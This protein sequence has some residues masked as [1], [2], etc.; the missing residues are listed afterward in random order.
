MKIKKNSPPLGRP[1]AFDSEKALESALQV[2]WERGYEGASLADL[3][4]AMGINRPSLYG[5]YGNKEALFLKV[6]D[7]YARGP[8]AFVQEAL[9]EPT[10]R[11]VAERMVRCAAESLGEID[12]PRGCLIVQSTLAC[13]KEANPIRKE[14][15]ARRA[16]GLAALRQR[17]ER[18]RSEGDLPV[19]S[20]STDL[21]RYIFSVIYGMAIQSVN[22]ATRAELHRVAEIALRAWPTES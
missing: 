13:G 8:G 11:R 14:L 18:A 10:A 15:I 4:R 19:K 7:R 16:A 22:G 2:F 17:F 9:R 5:A 20:N 3:T 21:A 12:K 6:L 1:R